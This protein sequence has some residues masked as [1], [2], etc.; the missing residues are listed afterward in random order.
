LRRPLPN[1]LRIAVA[2]HERRQHALVALVDIAIRHRLTYQMGPDS[3]TSQAVPGQNILPLLNVGIA[4]QGLCHLEVV[5]PTSQLQTVVAPCSG[6]LRQY[7]QRQIGE[8][9][10]EQ[11][12]RACHVP[13]LSVVTDQE[14]ATQYRLG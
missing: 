4:L 12:N 6:L 10:S 9:T 7:R 11:R 5:T 8:L 1:S 3:P 14:Y 2:P 13:F